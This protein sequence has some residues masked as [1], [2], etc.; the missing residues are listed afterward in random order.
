MD[1]IGFSA[2]LDCDTAPSCLP[3]RLF[4]CPSRRDASVLEGLLPLAPNWILFPLIGGPFLT[5]LEHRLEHPDDFAYQLASFF[6]VEFITIHEDGI[7]LLPKMA[8]WRLQLHKLLFV[9]YTVD[10][11]KKFGSALSALV[12]IKSAS[13]AP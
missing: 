11:Y 13:S 10:G 9:N 8:A 5:I 2:P 4:D 6:K 12:P 7:P 3:L 1:G